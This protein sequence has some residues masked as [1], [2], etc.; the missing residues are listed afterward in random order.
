[1]RIKICYNVEKIMNKLKSNGYDFIKL[2]TV[3]EDEDYKKDVECYYFAKPDVSSVEYYHSLFTSAV[4]IMKNGDRKKAFSSNVNSNDIKL[5]R[6]NDN[7]FISPKLNVNDVW[8]EANDEVTNWLIKHGVS[9]DLLESSRKEFTVYETV[10]Y[11]GVPTPSGSHG[12]WSYSSNTLV[13]DERE[14]EIVL[15][16][17][18]DEVLRKK[19]ECILYAKVFKCRY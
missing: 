7:D 3:M 8:I 14:I 18:E 6:I 13:L 11:Y 15:N 19:I 1:M 5:I 17:I 12:R 2:P 16:C 10:E 4:I 9:M